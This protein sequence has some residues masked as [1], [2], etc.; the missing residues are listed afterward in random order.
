MAEGF[1][2]SPSLRPP[3]QHAYRPRVHS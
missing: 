3:R 1:L 2:P